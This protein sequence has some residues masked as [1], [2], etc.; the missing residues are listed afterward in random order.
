[1]DSSNNIIEKSALHDWVENETCALDVVASW[2][3]LCDV[4]RTLEFSDS[5]S[6]TMKMEEFKW[7][8][9]EMNKH[10]SRARKKLLT[11]QSPE[12]MI[13]V[14]SEM[15][16]SA[17]TTVTSRRDL[18]YHKLR[19]MWVS[20]MITKLT[21]MIQETREKEEEEDGRTDFWND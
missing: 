3:T 11:C 9:A 14:L 10:L 21:M 12:S 8:I 19:Q 6:D 4:Y 15:F 18:T 17:G 1:M 13:E 7:I 5:I 16:T 20:Q 2:E